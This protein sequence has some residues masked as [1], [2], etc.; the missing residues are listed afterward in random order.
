MHTSLILIPPSNVVRGKV[1]FSVVCVCLLTGVVPVQGPGP[2][3]TRSQQLPPSPDMFKLVQPRPDSH[4]TWPYL[5][6]YMFKLVKCEVRTVGKQAVCHS[7]EMLSY[8]QSVFTPCC[9]LMANVLTFYK[10]HHWFTLDI[11]L[12][13]PTPE[14]IF[15]R[16]QKSGI[17]PL[18]HTVYRGKNRCSSS[19]KF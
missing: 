8:N 1:V 2:S 7:S 10:S 15:I 3:C 19:W 4:C 12:A 16:Q 11:L 17:F 6:L 9:L 13:P 14:M 5:L 18:E